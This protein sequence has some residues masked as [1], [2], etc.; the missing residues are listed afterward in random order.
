MAASLFKTVAVVGISGIVALWLTYAFDVWY[1]D[2][3]RRRRV[4]RG[5]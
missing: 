1:A 4:K 5:T 2:C 3:Q